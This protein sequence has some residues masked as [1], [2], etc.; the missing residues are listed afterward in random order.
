MSLLKLGLE[1][2]QHGLG[3]LQF[4]LF[5]KHLMKKSINSLEKDSSIFFL[6]LDNFLQKIYLTITR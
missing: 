6:S 5:R 4:N 3:F 2:P 1:Q